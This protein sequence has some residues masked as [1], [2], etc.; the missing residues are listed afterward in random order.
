MIVYSAHNGSYPRI[1]DT[2]E[3]QKLRRAH[4][5]LEKGEKSPEEFHAIQDEV[6]KEVIEEQIRAGMDFVSDGLIRWNDPLSHLAGRLE[7][8]EINGLLRF[9]DTNYLFRQPV[10]TAPVRWTRPILNDELNYAK[11]IS[12]KPVIAVLTGPYTLAKLS[13][14]KNKDYKNINSLFDDYTEAIR[15]EVESLVKEN[16]S[17]IQIDE[18]MI[19]QNPQDFP[20]LEK[21]IVSIASIKGTTKFGLCTYFGDAAPLYQQF[22]KLPID[23]LTFDFTYSKTLTDI[24]VHEGSQKALGL[25]LI[26]GRNTRMERAE[27]IVSLLEKIIPKISAGECY[28]VPSCGLEYLPRDRALQKLANLHKIR[29]SFAPGGKL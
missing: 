24:I 5:A 10:I 3:Q 4:T 26:D 7:G 1:G 2:P 19:L 22:Q 13:M 18:P 23:I 27:D 21:S 9:F 29:E 16:A 28:L 11:K 25:G 20:L 12:S 17:Y 15:R 8:I 6:V 14:N